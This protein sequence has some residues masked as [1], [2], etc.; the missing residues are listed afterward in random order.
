MITMSKIDELIDFYEQ[1]LHEQ[2][3]TFKSIGK[4]SNNYR[5]LKMLNEL[6]EYRKHRNYKS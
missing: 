4:M 5:I 6:Y 2:Q 1:A 3:F